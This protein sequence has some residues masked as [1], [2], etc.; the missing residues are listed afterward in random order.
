MLVDLNGNL[1]IK[2]NKYMGW[3]TNFNTDVYLSRMTFTDV[4]DV[5]DKINENNNYISDLLSQIKMIGSANPKDII[6]ED[7]KEEPIR[8]ISNEID[9][10]MEQILDFE[11]EN[12]RLN[13]YEDYLLFEEKE[14]I[15]LSWKELKDFYYKISNGENLFEPTNKEQMNDILVHYKIKE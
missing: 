4:N 12:V 14:N 6:P 9:S 2:K 10:L 1:I 15:V 3:G 7:W 8:W 11:R 13:Q 5:K